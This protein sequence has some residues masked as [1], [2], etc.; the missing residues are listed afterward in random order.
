MKSSFSYIALFFYIL[1]CISC[2]HRL[3]HS[4]TAPQLTERLRP[5]VSNSGELSSYARVLQA[6]VEP[7]RADIVRDLNARLFPPGN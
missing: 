7:E 4:R 5:L 3:S 6:A 2:H 1:S